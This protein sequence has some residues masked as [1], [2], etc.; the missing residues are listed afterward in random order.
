MFS[1]SAAAVAA[2]FA[3]TIF[4]AVAVFF[5]AT[6]V[7]VALFFLLLAV[8]RRPSVSSRLSLSPFLP[9]RCPFTPASRLRTDL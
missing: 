7:L 1:R 5:F 9:L 2:P 8:R 6:A 4:F 3:V